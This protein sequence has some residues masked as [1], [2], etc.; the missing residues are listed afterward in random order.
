[1]NEPRRS[2]RGGLLADGGRALC[3]RYNCSRPTNGERNGRPLRAGPIP[4]KEGVLSQLEANHEEMTHEYGT[5][6]D[7]RQRCRLSLAQG[8]GSEVNR[9]Q[10][11]TADHARDVQSTEKA[12]NAAGVGQTEQ[13]EEATDRDA[14]GRR[15]WEIMPDADEPEEDVVSPGEVRSKDPTGAMGGRLDLTG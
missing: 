8:Q 3:G 7:D 12:E 5:F 6:G 10:Q 1:M 14:D 11:E 13:D 2:G 9:T 4:I 15:P